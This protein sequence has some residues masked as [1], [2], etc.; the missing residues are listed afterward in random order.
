VGGI[1]ICYRRED[2]GYAAGRLYDSLGQRF[3]K[4]QIFLDVDNIEPGQTFVEASHSYFERSLNRGSRH[5]C[6]SC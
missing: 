2:D 1:F 5:I 6:N 3:S 4:D